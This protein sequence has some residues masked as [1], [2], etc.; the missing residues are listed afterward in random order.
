[1]ISKEML[2]KLKE[3]GEN[4]E[5]KDAADAVK[6]AGDIINAILTGKQIDVAYLSMFIEAKKKKFQK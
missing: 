1:V 2:D 5:T 6:F 4:S 3:S